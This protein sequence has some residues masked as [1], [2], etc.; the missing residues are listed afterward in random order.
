MTRQAANSTEWAVPGDLGSATWY[1]EQFHAIDD[2]LVPGG[3]VAER[4]ADF[5]MGSTGKADPHAIELG[6]GTGRVARP[7]VRRGAVVTGVDAS[8]LMLD[9]CRAGSGPADTGLR[10]VEA[11]IRDWQPPRQADL[12]YCVGGTMS[13][14]TTRQDQRRAMGVIA[15]AVRPGGTVVIENN[16]PAFVRLLHHRG[17]SVALRTALVGAS[18]PVDVLC[19]FDEDEGIWQVE[20]RWTEPAGH[21]GVAIERMLLTDLDE[22]VAMAAA[23]GLSSRAVYG[24]WLGAP[25]HPRC[26]SYVCVL[27]AP[28]PA[29]A[30]GR[31]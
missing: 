18:E 20:Y 28:E 9:A 25:L 11:D 6:V 16:N 14:L 2:R 4:T 26:P 1:G 19:L 17:P 7:L 31:A 10:L 22:T 15:A 30:G 24:D 3:E 21:T 29:A 13:F 23:A 27:T 5:L 8:P 12:V